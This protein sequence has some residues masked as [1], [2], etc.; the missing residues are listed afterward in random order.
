MLAMLDQVCDS[1]EKAASSVP[2]VSQQSFLKVLGA[3]P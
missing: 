2:A 1:A 3:C